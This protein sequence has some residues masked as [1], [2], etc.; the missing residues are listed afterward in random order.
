[1]SRNSSTTVSKMGI[2]PKVL[3]SIHI[4]SDLAEG[5]ITRLEK[6]VLKDVIL[7]ERGEEIKIELQGL[8]TSFANIVTCYDGDSKS[9]SLISSKKGFYSNLGELIGKISNLEEE[10]IL[11]QNNVED[12]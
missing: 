4:F 1:M 5:Q 12:K 6:I 2:A 7:K 9:G 10:S 3:A 11:A 8:I